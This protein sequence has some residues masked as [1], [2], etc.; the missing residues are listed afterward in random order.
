VLVVG[1]AAAGLAASACCQREGLTCVVI[2]K[3]EASGDI[4]RSRYH[5]LH[6]HDIIEEC[7]LPLLQMPATYPTYPSREQFARYLANYRSVLGLRVEYRSLVAG[8]APSQAAGGGWAVDVAR[9][10]GASRKRFVAR[11]VIFANGV[12][13]DALLPPLQGKGRFCGKIVHSSRY[14]NATD[15]GWANGKRVLVVGWGNSGSEIALDLVEHGA[16]P[17]LLAR[18]PQVVVPRDHLQLAQRLLHSH[19]NPLLALPFGWLALLPVLLLT[20]PVLKLA[21]RIKY[22]GSLARAGLP[23][24]WKGPLLRL[25]TEGVPPMMDVGTVQACIDG[26]IAVRREGLAGID[27]DGRVV[28]SDGSAEPFDG[29]VLA[30]GYHLFSGHR[31][32]LD[33][34]SLQRLGTGKEAIKTGSVVPGCELRLP[35]VWALFGR[36]Q[37]IRDAAPALGRR[38][39]RRVHGGSRWRGAASW[40]WWVV[41]HVLIAWAVLAARRRLKQKARQLR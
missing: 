26:R 37:M 38:I 7:H 17:T 10:D 8:M 27:A 23:Q 41:E 18:S 34:A 13:N 4:W 14:T 19:L 15:L 9:L 25:L 12:Y 28:F 30:T 3:N 1:G 6:L 2:E 24:H 29:I 16:R 36:L 5:R 11:N 32:F 22:G 21:A 20:D 33:A 39:A 35:N 31:H 40:V